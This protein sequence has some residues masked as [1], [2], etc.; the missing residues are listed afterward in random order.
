MYPFNDVK[1]A[2]FIRSNK[3]CQPPTYTPLPDEEGTGLLITGTILVKLH[4]SWFPKTAGAIAE[5]QLRPVDNPDNFIGMLKAFDS[6]IDKEIHP[7]HLKADEG[8]YHGL[9]TIYRE[10]IPSDMP[11]GE[12]PPSKIW[13]YPDNQLDIFNGST[14]FTHSDVSPAFFLIDD[15]PVGMI[16][17]MN[18]RKSQPSIARAL[19]NITFYEVGN[20]K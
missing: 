6:G 13:L 5:C 16:L 9:C 18:P 19:A 15:E 10:K 14:F 12:I 17:P 11:I 7:T 3:D 4:L 1:L 8:K 2:K 20:A